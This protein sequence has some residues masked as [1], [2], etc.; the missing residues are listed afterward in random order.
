MKGTFAL[1]LL[2]SLV[3]LCRGKLYGLISDFSN[4]Y[5]TTTLNI[6]EVDTNTGNFTYLMEAFAYLGSSLTY[7][8]ISTFDQKRGN[9]YFSDNFESH[10]IFSVNVDTPALGFPISIPTIW[11][12]SIV[13]DYQRDNIYVVAGFETLNYTVL[14]Y[15]MQISLNGGLCGMLLNMTEVGIGFLYGQSTMDY[16]TGTYYL[17]ADTSFASFNVENPTDV[18]TA[19][20]LCNDFSTVFLGYDY[21]TDSLIGVGLG[22]KR[23]IYAFLRFDISSSEV[24]CTATKIA[25]GVEGLAMSYSF[26]PTEEILYIGF[27]PNPGG[28][29]LAIYDINANTVTMKKTP[30]ILADIQVTYQPE[31]FKH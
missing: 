10:F 29:E 28:N 31:L 13:Y 5:T 20:V 22:T 25:F 18:T 17:I 30:W 1:V 16:T 27:A 3:S 8:G 9:L 2:L 12:Q 6:V 4:N 24:T 26:D 19:T 11:V 15:L 14:V 21:K 23:Q 7:T